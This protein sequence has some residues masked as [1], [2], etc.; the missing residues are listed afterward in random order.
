MTLPG[1]ILLSCYTRRSH[2]SSHLPSANVPQETCGQVGI[3]L[4]IGKLRPRASKIT[5]VVQ[6]RRGKGTRTQRF[7]TPKYTA[8]P[9]Q[10]AAQGWAGLGW[11]LDVPYHPSAK[12]MLHNSAVH[13]SHLPV[14][15]CPVLGRVWS[16]RI[17]FK[18]DRQL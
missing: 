9:L 16:L 14:P 2:N 6:I 17:K 3:S 12:F 13:S 1:K 5:Q 7:L 10:L 18:E 15:L 11:A 8:Y 4:Q